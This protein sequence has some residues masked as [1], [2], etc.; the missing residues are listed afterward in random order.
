MS[1]LNVGS[2][3]LFGS[4][5]G[6]VRYYGKLPVNVN[7]IY[8]GIEIFMTDSDYGNCDGTFNNVRYFSCPPKHGIFVEAD[9]I[10]RTIGSEELLEKLVTLH[11]RQQ[12]L[13]S[14]NKRLS[15][16]CDSYVRRAAHRDHS[17]REMVKQE[18]QFNNEI[19]ILKERLIWYEKQILS[20]KSIN[21]IK[22]IDNENDEKTKNNSDD[23]SKK[24]TFELEMDKLYDMIVET[25]FYS[26]DNQMETMK[27]TLI[28]N[29]EKSLIYDDPI[30]GSLL[31]WSIRHNNMQIFN[32]LL[33]MGVDVNV[34]SN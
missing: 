23:E 16:S 15:S 27:N 6:I 21:K 30:K 7:K 3:V 29:K 2:V 24:S 10:K 25:V 11:T 4:R 13:E 33:E 20:N 22:N 5:V 26:T 31:N 9:E 19:A 32:T 18:T 12:K 8:A 14:E 17:I 34:V 1:S 28:K